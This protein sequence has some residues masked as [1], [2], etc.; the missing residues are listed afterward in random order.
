MSL[1][2]LNQIKNCRYLLKQCELS[3]NIQKT[4]ISSVVLSRNYNAICY[5]PKLIPLYYC[6]NRYDDQKN[7]RKV[8]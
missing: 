7:Y 5:K 3:V 4:A 8:N 1:R 2:I 6:R